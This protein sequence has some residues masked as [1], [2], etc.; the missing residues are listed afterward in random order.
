MQG[1]PNLKREDDLMKAL[2]VINDPEIHVPITDM[3][4]IYGVQRR[5]KD[6]ALVTMTLT[7]IGCPLFDVIKYEVE[8]EL[9]KI[10]GIKTV[11]IDL[12][13]DPPWHTGM[14]SEEIQ[15]DLGLL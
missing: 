14:M 4:L 3:G 8:T 7:T 6:E 12:T 10:E 5:G 9:E 2:S 1:I 13:F 11:T 15:L